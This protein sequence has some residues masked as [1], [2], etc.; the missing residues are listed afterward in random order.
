M[1]GDL[2]QGAI[3][4]AAVLSPRVYAN[5]PFRPR[6]PDD[7][8][9]FQTR[10]QPYGHRRTLEVQH[11]LVGA[12][13]EVVGRLHDDA[14]GTRS[15]VDSRDGATAASYAAQA[16]RARPTRVI[17]KPSRISALRKPVS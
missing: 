11:D 7:S 17:F 13:A 9:H 1:V 15:G 2:Y 5:H 6:P 16:F 14:R 8:R 4:V 3:G 10:G 12:E